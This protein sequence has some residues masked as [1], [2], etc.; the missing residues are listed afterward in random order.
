LGAELGALVVDLDGVEAALMAYD[1]DPT[2]EHEKELRA[3]LAAAGWHPEDIERAV[4]QGR[5]PS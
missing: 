3:V 1:A 4:E 5:R 2:P